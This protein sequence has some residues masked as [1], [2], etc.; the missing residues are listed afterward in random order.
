MGTKYQLTRPAKASF[1]DCVNYALVTMPQSAAATGSS[2]LIQG[3]GSASK[4][5]PIACD[6]SR[7]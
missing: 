1:T 2:N 5:E 3:F 7:A 6:S 4:T